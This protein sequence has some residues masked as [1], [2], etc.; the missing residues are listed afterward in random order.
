LFQ[1]SSISMPVT[2]L[3]VLRLV[4][5]GKLNLDADVF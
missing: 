4:E 5:K 3:A 2:A 1:A